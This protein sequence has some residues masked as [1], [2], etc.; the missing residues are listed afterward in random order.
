MLIGIS[1]IPKIPMGNPQIPILLLNGHTNSSSWSKD[2]PNWNYEISAYIRIPS[3]SAPNKKNSTY[4]SQ[5]G[6][7]GIILIMRTIFS[8]FPIP[9]R[10][11][12][13][14]VECFICQKI[15]VI[16]VPILAI[17]NPLTFSILNKISGPAYPVIN[18]VRII[19]VV[20]TI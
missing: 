19:L 6:A 1:K 15:I 3:I 18:L 4:P 13:S 14:D 10:Y 16:C 9:Q 5:A 2:P 7:I 17:L 11:S 8:F 12:L 20:I